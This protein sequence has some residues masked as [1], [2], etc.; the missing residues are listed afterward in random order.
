MAK[1]QYFAGCDYQDDIV[2][3]DASSLTDAKHKASRYY[4]D[5]YIGRRYYVGEIIETQSGIIKI[6]AS[7]KYIGH[8]GKWRDLI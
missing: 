8:T 3:I 4:A 2:K 1:N 7:E 5:G 6:I